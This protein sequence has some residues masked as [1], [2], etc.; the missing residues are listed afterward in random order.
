MTDELIQGLAQ[1]KRHQYGEDGAM[2]K[3]VEEGQTPKYFI[4]SC[5]DSRANPGVIFRARPGVFFAH[6]AM[7]AIVRPYSQETALS[8]ALQF[9]LQYNEVDT[10]IIMGHTQCGAIKALAENIDDDAISSFISIAKNALKRAQC[11]CEGQDAI[12]ARTEQDVILESARNIVKYPSV[13]KALAEERITIKPWLF[14]MK[15]GDLLEYNEASKS[16]EVI[17]PKT[18]LEDSRQHA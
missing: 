13:K 1:F 3:L 9:A 16:F 4:I 12:L 18:T 7:G 5:I 14:D 17:T 8:A 15:E 10:I 2:S 11:E 6:K